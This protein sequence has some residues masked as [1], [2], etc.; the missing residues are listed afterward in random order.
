[1]IRVVG[2]AV[3][4]NIFALLGDETLYATPDYKALVESNAAMLAAYRAQ[5]WEELEKALPLLKS[6]L[7]AM[8]LAL[9]EYLEMYETR[10]A[11]LR[12]NSPG[13]DWDGV[14]ASTKK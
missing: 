11:N 10:L 2:K 1:M 13:P 14:F 3:P 4:E 9:D 12:E 8:G 7:N 6:C 5:N